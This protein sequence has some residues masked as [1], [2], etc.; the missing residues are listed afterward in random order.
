MA[1]L[2]EDELQ[3]PVSTGGNGAHANMQP[4]LFLNT[5]IKL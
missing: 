2:I 4:T 5:M 3:P 1:G